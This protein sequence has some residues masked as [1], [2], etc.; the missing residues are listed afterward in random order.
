M[1]PGVR[2]VSLGGEFTYVAEPPAGVPMPPP[3][4]PDP[5]LHGTTPKPS[6]VEKATGVVKDALGKG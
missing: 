1:R 2:R 4:Q 5:R 3:T 6:A